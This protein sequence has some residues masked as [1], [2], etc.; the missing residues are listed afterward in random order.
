M[1]R[2]LL[3]NAIAV[4][5]TAVS[6]KT[7]PAFRADF[8]NPS[9]VLRVTGGL[10]LVPS[11]E[12][13]RQTP[14]VEIKDTVKWIRES[15]DKTFA[16]GYGGVNI[17]PSRKPY[18]TD[19]WFD[20]YRIAAEYSKEKG[21]NIVMYDDIEF[22]S[23]TAGDR[24]AG[25]YPEHRVRLLT[26]TEKE[27]RG[28][29]NLKNLE[30]SFEGD[31]IGTVAFNSDTKE[32]INISDKLSGKLLS[33]NVPEGNW[34]VMTYSMVQRGRMIDLMDTAA[35]DKYIE[36]VYEKYNKELG[37]YFG[38][39]IDRNFFDDI[40]FWYM[41]NPWNSTVNETFKI[42]YGLDPLL[43][44]PALWYDIGGDTKA[45]RVAFFSICAEKMGD[46]FAKRL[47]DWCTAHGL[48]NMGH[49]PGAYDPNPTF[50]NGD[51]FKFYK[52]QQ[53]PFLDLI[54]GYLSG[55]PGIK[56]TSSVAAIYNRPVTG[57]EIF[58]AYSDMNGDMLYRVPMES[59]TRGISYFVSFAAG[60]TTYDGTS[61]RETH[62]QTN[63]SYVK[64][65]NDFMGR[66]NSLL[67]GGRSV[68][69]IVLVFPIE[70]LQA[71][72][73]YAE[74][75]IE[76]ER[77]EASKPKNTGGFF[78][79]GVSPATAGGYISYANMANLDF[80]APKKEFEF[81][82]ER[83]KGAGKNVHPSNDYNKISDLLTNQ[84]R[85]DFTFV[86]A[87]EFV[88]DKFTIEKGVVK[89]NATDTWQQ[90]KL[91]IMPSQQ[92]VKISIL[93]KLKSFYQAGGHILF[94]GELPF[95]AAE[96]GRDA[97]VKRLIK[98]LLG[99]A[100]Q[101]G[102]QISVTNPE[103]GKIIYIPL[104]SNNVL[105][106]AVDE[107]LPDADVKIT[108]VSDLE[109]EDLGNIVIGVDIVDKSGN[110]PDKYLGELSYLHKVKD[111][112]DIYCFVNSSDH[113]VNTIV[114]I[115]GKKNLEQWNPHNGKITNWDSEY[116]NENGVKYTVIKL[117]LDPVSAIFAVGK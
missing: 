5:I 54:G 8:E 32:R 1:K 77:L 86:E 62:P 15:L 9:A 107:L 116:V 69:D 67:Q 109:H 90:Y 102:K 44:M 75:I 80:R 61:Y 96:F 36:L 43:Y 70:S 79:G 39:V 6:C 27:F 114:K 108:P 88:K 11:G 105:K 59:F 71:N 10:S 2:T 110:M 93:E 25:Q 117:K 57:T 115:A 99:V 73:K 7:Q 111:N 40:G 101:P 89:L 29:L 63:Q 47:T 17:S 103:G 81:P 19:K 100:S 18:F 16:E 56:L 30:M 55:R 95:K 60:R 51:P 76:H 92:I 41:I 113:Q 20:K 66:S 97:E 91:V 49:V 64:E 21:K 24:I 13:G 83:T 87:D 74:D 65:W 26:K 84:L 72:E 104:A 23:G 38:N 31:L 37:K 3:I 85:H 78:F 33:W 58:G 12:F 4:I 50:M 46:V 22:P 53:I 42:R 82:S 34:K 48:N 14:T 68:V 28:P 98:E 94:T 45:S 35:M 52:Y 106:T 112:K